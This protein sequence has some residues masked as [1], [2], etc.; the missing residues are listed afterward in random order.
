SFFGPAT[1]KALKAYQLAN[2]IDAVGFM[3]PATMASL[4][5]AAPSPAG[6]N[7]PSIQSLM[8]QI[9]QLQDA[10]SRLLNR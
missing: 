7:Q 10:I 1:M 5:G 3:G 2:G 9:Q 6:G 8:L 4:N